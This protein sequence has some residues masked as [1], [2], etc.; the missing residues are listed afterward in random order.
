M[1]ETYKQ[2]HIQNKAKFTAMGI[3]LE[4]LDPDFRESLEELAEIGLAVGVDPLNASNFEIIKRVSDQVDQEYDVRLLLHEIK[5]LQSSIE[6]DLADM[7]SLK[8]C[9]EEIQQNQEG[10]RD[11]FDEKVSE[12]TTQIKSIQAKTDEYKSQSSNTKVPSLP[13]S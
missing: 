9:L 12:Y 6:K 7:I 5:T 4:S 10:Q 8:Q 1:L 3:N 11:L 13:L 2:I